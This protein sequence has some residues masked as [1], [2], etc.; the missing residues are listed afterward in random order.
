M[1]I[2]LG[3]G[4][5]LWLKRQQAVDVWKLEQQGDYTHIQQLKAA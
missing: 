4:A 2:R 5:G 3:K 1:A